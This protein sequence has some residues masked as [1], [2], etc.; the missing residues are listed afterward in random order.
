[1]NLKTV[2]DKLNKKYPSIPF[3]PPK[4]IVLENSSD[5]VLENDDEDDEFVTNNDNDVFDQSTANDDSS[6]IIE[7][8]LSAEAKKGF[9]ICICNNWVI[10]K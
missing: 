8:N 5:K 4:D 2:A 1:M 9:E 10:R 7:T 6:D 3:F